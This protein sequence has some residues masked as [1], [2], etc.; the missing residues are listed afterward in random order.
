[1]TAYVLMLP[2]LLFVAWMALRIKKLQNRGKRSPLNED[3]SLFTAF[4]M[5]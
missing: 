3:I 2:A 1:M 5:L 4:M